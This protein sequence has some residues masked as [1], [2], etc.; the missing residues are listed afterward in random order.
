MPNVRDDF[1]AHVSMYVIS[2]VF[3]KLFIQEEW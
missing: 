2:N 1:L 3:I